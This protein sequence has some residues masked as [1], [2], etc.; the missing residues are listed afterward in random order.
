MTKKVLM[1]KTIQQ[2]RINF[3]C[4]KCGIE[5]GIVP[6]ITLNLELEPVEFV[7]YDPELGMYLINNEYDYVDYNNDDKSF[8]PDNIDIFDCNC[9]GISGQS[10]KKFNFGC[11]NPE[12]DFVFKQ[13]S[14]KSLIK[15]LKDNKFLENYGEI[16]HTL[17]VF[18]TGKYQCLEE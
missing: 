1:D 8:N 5:G 6:K 16:Q 9:N 2:Y 7:E 11:G 4:P 15:Y 17:P 14:E 12:C 10:I 18:E 13:K 3:T